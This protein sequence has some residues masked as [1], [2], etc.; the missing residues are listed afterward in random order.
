M[1]RR[2]HET[3]AV[4]TAGGQNVLLWLG[5][6]MPLGGW[7][8]CRSPLLRYCRWRLSIPYNMCHR[9]PPHVGVS[10]LATTSQQESPPLRPKVGRKC[11]RLAPKSVKGGRKCDPASKKSAENACPSAED[12]KTAS[13]RQPDPSILVM[14][15]AYRNT[16]RTLGPS[17]YREK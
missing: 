13:A 10:Q 9:R 7:R 15:T 3:T 11:N 17:L 14:G 4:L 12:G 2:Y 8:R 6:G 16:M 1:Q 5:G